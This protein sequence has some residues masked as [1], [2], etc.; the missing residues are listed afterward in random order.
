MKERSAEFALDK[1]IKKSVR[2]LCNHGPAD[3]AY[4]LG[5]CLFR[6]T[7]GRES[8][9]IRPDSNG[10]RFRANRVESR[11]D[12]SS[13]RFWGLQCVLLCSFTL[14]TM[15]TKRMKIE[16]NRHVEGRFASRNLLRESV[17]LDESGRPNPNTIRWCVHRAI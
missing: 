15:F 12:G 4:T 1:I 8:K 10:W 17:E 13:E 3:S 7:A 14:C 11:L 2:A 16:L 5:S 6:G 9:F